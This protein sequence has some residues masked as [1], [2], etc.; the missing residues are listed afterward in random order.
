M[1]AKRL[2]GLK[3]HKGDELDGLEQQQE[4]VLDFCK[5]QSFQTKTGDMKSK[6]LFS[7]MIGKSS[8]HTGQDLLRAGG[9]GAGEG[10]F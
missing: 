8:V 9:W 1:W 7:S 10:C 6:E 3:D 2:A 5:R 4:C